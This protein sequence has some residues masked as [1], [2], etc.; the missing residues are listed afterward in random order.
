M[1][2]ELLSDTDYNQGEDKRF[3]NSVLIGRVAEIDGATGR[4]RVL[5]PDK[6]DH[7]DQ[8]LVTKFIPVLQVASRAKKSYAMPRLGTNITIIKMPNGTCDYLAVGMF[9]TS[10]EPPPVSDPKLDYVIYDDGSIMKFDATEGSLTWDFKGG[11]DIKTKKDIK[12]TTTDGAKV[13]IVSDG[14]VNVKANGTCKIEAPMIELKG[15]V[16]IEGDITHTGNMETSGVHQ[17]SRGYHVS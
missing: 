7:K 16:T 9:Y 17:D 1:L 15:A 3:R 4:V 14:D 5:L 12:I 13:E 11:I 6:L 10:K 2:K 8:P